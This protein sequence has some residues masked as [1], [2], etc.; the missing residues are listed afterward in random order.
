MDSFWLSL[1]GRQWVQL[2][3]LV[4]NAFRKSIDIGALTHT[5]LLAVLLEIEACIKS[6]PFAFV[7]DDMEAKRLW[8][9]HI[10][11]WW[12]LQSG[13]CETC[14]DP[15][16]LSLR[17]QLCQTALQQFWSEWLT[18]YVRNSPEVADVVK[19]GQ[20]QEGSLVLVQGDTPHRL[21]WHIG[22]VTQVFP[23]RD[24]VI[25]AVEMS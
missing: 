9:L 14:P 5:E 8:P 13:P 25:R 21:S 2:L 20:V 18:E 7:E 4:T 15:E 19:G 10:F 11:T 17:W 23:G 12:L 6:R 16:S 24:R 1:F 3:T 22:V